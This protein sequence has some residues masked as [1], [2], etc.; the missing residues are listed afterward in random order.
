[1]CNNYSIHIL[2]KQH[3]AFL[4]TDHTLIYK[5]NISN[6]QK[7]E[8]IQTTVYDHNTI[9]LEINNKRITK[10]F[11]KLRCRKLR[12]PI[13]NNLWAK[14]E[15]MIEIRKYLYCMAKNTIIRMY[16]M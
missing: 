15:I 7:T 4:K 13:L 11:F 9:K 16:S 6:F 5:T 3:G 12:C 14:K 8:I 2:C 1:M 10:F